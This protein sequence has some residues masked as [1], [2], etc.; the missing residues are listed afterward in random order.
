M[1]IARD[2]EAVATNW[3]SGTVGTENLARGWSAAT[4]DD[5]F[6]NSAVAPSTGAG[7]LYNS[8][9]NTCAS[10]GTHKLRRT[11]QLS[12]GSEVWDFAG[13]VWEWA[14]WNTTAGFTSGPTDGTAAWQELSS[15]SGS[16]TA[17]DL[18]SNGGYTSTQQAGRWYGG[19]GGAALR[20]GD[21]SHGSH[22]GAFALHLSAAS[23]NTG[24]N[25]GFRCVF[26]P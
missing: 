25:I 21:W 24:T 4:G 18:Q 16:V 9:A 2:L 23:T 10:T 19:S 20:G 7:C 11:H 26:R 13:N 3:S 1:T 6:Q 5:G 12:N 8:A 14:D 17:D 15:L 22:A